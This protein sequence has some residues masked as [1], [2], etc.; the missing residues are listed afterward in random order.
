MGVGQFRFPESDDQNDNIKWILNAFQ[1]IKKISVPQLC[2]IIIIFAVWA[3]HL[4]QKLLI[5]IM[6]TKHVNN[7]SNDFINIIIEEFDIKS[8]DQVLVW[9]YHVL[10]IWGEQNLILRHPQ[11]LDLTFWT[12]FFEKIQPRSMGLQ[13]ICGAIFFGYK[14]VEH[15][16]HEGKVRFEPK[17]KYH[18]LP[19]LNV[20]D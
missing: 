3:I 1:K 19:F 5:T 2:I 13:S 16:L 14:Q 17:F 12:L 9:L 20:Q 4:F 11:H 6:S 15:G 8:I 10:Q 7:W 18:N